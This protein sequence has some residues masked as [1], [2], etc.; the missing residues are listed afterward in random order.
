MFFKIIAS[1]LI[2]LQPGAV[3]V[4]K[5]AAVVNSEIITVSDI[6]KSLFFYSPLKN[7]GGD[8]KDLY[9]IELDNL[10]NY[11]VVFLE[12]KDQFKLKREDFEDVQRTMIERYGSLEN[13]VEIL[14]KFDMDMADFKVFLTEKILY[15][16]VIRDKYKLG[17]IVEFREI[18]EFYNKEYLPSQ[19]AINLEPKSIIEMAPE[20]E[21]H[22]RG[23][24]VLEKLSGWLKNLKS[25]Y[26]IKNI[27]SLEMGKDG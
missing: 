8:D 15:D 19:R 26:S 10:I 24:M 23:E 6:D 22:L 1:L 5:I 12:F 9:L 4:D 18:E 25:S 14:R 21:R 27:L 7:T 13:L 3:L 11:K 20:I 2:A 16:K 17:I